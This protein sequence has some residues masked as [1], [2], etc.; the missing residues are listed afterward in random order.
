MEIFLDLLCY[1]LIIL[2]VI[3][4]FFCFLF[5]VREIVNM[6]FMNICGIFIGYCKEIVV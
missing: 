5:Y 4:K 6:G 1:F 3:E 2:D